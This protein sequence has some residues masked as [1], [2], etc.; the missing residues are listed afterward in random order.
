MNSFG[1]STSILEERQS[2]FQFD[3]GLKYTAS[4]GLLTALCMTIKMTVGPD[5]QVD[6]VAK[7][8]AYLPSWY[9]YFR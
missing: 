9:V 4:L 7:E 2:C 1:F 5:F 8:T 6:T 3:S